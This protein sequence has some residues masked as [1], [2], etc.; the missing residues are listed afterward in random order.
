MM[1][2]MVR[3]WRGFGFN[4]AGWPALAMTLGW[5]LSASATGVR[6]GEDGPRA[7]SGT[8]G[9]IVRM[10]P[11]FDALVPE[12][13]KIER[14]ATGFEWSEGPVWDPAAGAVYFSDIPNNAVMKWKD[15]E[16]LSLFLKPAGYTGTAARGGETGSNGLLL[17]KSGR[18]VLC[19]HGDRRIARLA[20]DGKS[21]ETLA[22]RYM[23]KRFNSPNDAVYHSNGDLYFTD[24]PYGLE[25]QMDDPLK[26]L[27]FQGVYRLGKDGKVTLLTKEM[28]RPNGIALSPDEKT[29]YVANSD[30]K[31][32]IWMAFDVVGDGTIANGRVFADVTETVGKMKGLPDGLKLDTAGNLF[33]TGPGG[34]LVFNPSG[35]LLGRIDPGNATANCG[36]G[37]DG[38]TL[39]ITSD[40]DFCRIRLTTT[41]LGFERK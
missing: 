15:G 8:I 3:A 20:A 12:G 26:E 5:A 10:D 36:F 33:A 25:K 9:E 23:G 28:S 29:L 27:D 41:G 14:L 4:A 24:P 40:M 37:D 32:A 16:G 19:Q 39:Y 6:A 13:A 22:D 18:L 30:P 31:K 35:K 17:D 38:S 2:G 34:V 1:G 7:A 21:F 11:A